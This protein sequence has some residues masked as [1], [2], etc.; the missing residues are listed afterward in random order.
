MFS[1]SVVLVKDDTRSRGIWQKVAAMVICFAQKTT[2]IDGGATDGEFYVDS[3]V[4]ATISGLTIRN[5]NAGDTGAGGGIDNFS[6]AV[7]WA[8]C[9]PAHAASVLLLPYFSYYIF[10]RKTPRLWLIT[11][12]KKA[13][14]LSTFF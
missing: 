7:W 14:L 4:A 13:I 2:A 9:R 3:G 5:G 12:G 8:S 1:A 11:R 6:A 10:P